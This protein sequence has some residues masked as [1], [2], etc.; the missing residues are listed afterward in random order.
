MNNLEDKKIPL[1][2]GLEE[3]LSQKIDLWEEFE[4]AERN[5]MLISHKKRESKRFKNFPIA[6]AVAAALIAGVFIF[7]PLHKHAQARYAH[8]QA[9][10]ALTLLSEEL[11]LCKN[12]MASLDNLIDTQE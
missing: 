10:Y 7:F 9:V 12:E 3:R 5:R 1:P 6:A 8:E 11:T 2:D 4:C